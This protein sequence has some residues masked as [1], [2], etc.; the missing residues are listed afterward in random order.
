M[1]PRTPA[2]PRAR[3]EPRA[4]FTPDGSRVVFRNSTAPDDLW[5]I[6]VADGQ[7]SGAPEL[8]KSG[9]GPVMGFARD[10]SFYYSDRTFRQGVYVAEVDPATWKLK[11]CSQGNLQPPA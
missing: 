5:S 10:G 7:P 9:T 6:P 1:A 3:R 11:N 2:Y 4:L 8:A